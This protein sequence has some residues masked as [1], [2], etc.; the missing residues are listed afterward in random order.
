MDMEQYD[1]GHEYR[2]PEKNV[3]GIV[4][5]ALSFCTGPIGLII[6]LIALKDR[7]R[8]FAIAGVI[9]SLISTAVL[10]AVAWFFVWAGG[11][12]MKVVETVQDYSTISNAISQYQGSNNGQLPPDLNALGLSS[13]VTTDAWGVP[14]RYEP[15]PDGQS[16]TLTTAGMDKTMGTADDASLNSGMS[17]DEVGDAMGEQVGKYYEE[18]FGG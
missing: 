13:D 4:G 12:G 18:K 14:Y 9:I 6:S 11:I 15:S 16:W 5:F 3:L 17:E 8:G 2:E 7:P 10:G 1:P